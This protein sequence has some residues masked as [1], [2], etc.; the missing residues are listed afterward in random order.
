MFNYSR[1]VLEKSIISTRRID[2]PSRDLEGHV[3]AIPKHAIF[4]HAGTKPHVIL[5]KKPGGVLRF[6]TRTGVVVY[7]RMVKHP[8]TAP[9]EF[10]WRAL[11]RIA[12]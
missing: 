2:L 1:G 3:V 7:A 8:G 11:K 6:R 5:P 9:N 4:V 12:P 10:L